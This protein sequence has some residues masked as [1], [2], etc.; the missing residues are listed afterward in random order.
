MIKE[1]EGRG[2]RAEAI[3]LSVTL[4]GIVVLAHTSLQ[5]RGDL[6]SSIQFL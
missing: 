5:L 1:G 4:H 6:Y 2:K 3:A